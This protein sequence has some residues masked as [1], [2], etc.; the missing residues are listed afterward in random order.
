M[1]YRLRIVILDVLPFLPLIAVDTTV[2]LPPPSRSDALST[3]AGG[4]RRAAV[5]VV[6]NHSC[7]CPSFLLVV[8][9]KSSLCVERV[10]FV[11]CIVVR[12]CSLGSKA[13]QLAALGGL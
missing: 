2:T 4:E 6:T 10:L 7:H 1:G 12:G 13:T 5:P 11:V 3:R 9:R 8:C